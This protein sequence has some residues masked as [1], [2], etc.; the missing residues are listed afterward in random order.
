MKTVQEAAKQISDAERILIVC[1]VSPDGDAI[2]SMLG[3]GLTLSEAQKRVILCCADPVPSQYRYLPHWKTIARSCSERC[4]L[5]VTLDCSDLDRLGAV[6]DPSTLHDVPIVNIDHHTT[7]V[8]FGDV[9]WVEP[10]AAA[11]AQM[12]VRLVHGLG[13][14]LN[15]D[16]ATC[17]LTG[18]LTDTLGFRTSATTPEVMETAIQLMKAGASLPELTD[19]IFGRRPMRTIEMW[20]TTLQ[21]LHLEGHILWTEITQ[22]MRRRI[23]YQENGDAG[24]AN[25]LSTANE[26]DIAIIFDEQQDGQVNV[27]MRCVPGYDVSQVAF[28]LGGGGHAQAAGCTLSGPLEGARTRVLSMLQKSWSMQNSSR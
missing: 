7:N 26:A 3:L 21:N 19:R 6:Y 8:E 20:A 9:N 16:I 24:L 10:E 1:H 14:S 2:G 28:D 23:G 4:D 13:I 12:L 25:F 15:A 17:L 22:R 18:I 11:T 5:L 27:S